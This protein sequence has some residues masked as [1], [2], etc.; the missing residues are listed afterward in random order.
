MWR[1]FTPLKYFLIKGNGKRTFD[2]MLPLLFCALFC[3]PLLSER[4]IESAFAGNDVF[5]APRTFVGILF[6]FFIAALAAVATFGNPEMDTPLSDLRL[7]HK[8]GNFS[9]SLS[10]RRFLAFLFGYLAYL[11]LVFWFLSIAYGYAAEFVITDWELDNRKIV[12][13]GAWIIQSLLMGSLLSNT[14][15]GLFYLADRINRPNAGPPGR[16]QNDHENYSSAPAE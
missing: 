8:N 15:L 16:D 5:E 6:G 3:A 14:L 7:Y 4:F 12:F 9:E 13:C 11:S 1:A 2:V 10:R